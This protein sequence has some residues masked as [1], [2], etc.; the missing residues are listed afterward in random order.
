MTLTGLTSDS[1]SIEGGQ[2]QG[3]RPLW[4][5]NEYHLSSVKWCVQSV[6]GELGGDL[7]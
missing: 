3:A 5:A 1:Y 2:D 6:E 4:A 7:S